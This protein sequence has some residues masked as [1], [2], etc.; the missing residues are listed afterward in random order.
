VHLRKAAAGLLMATS[1]LAVAT[2]VVASETVTHSY[3]ALGRLVTT[4]SS[5][6]VNNGLSTSIVFD[7][8]GNR[9]TY[10]VTG[11]G[12][13][14][15]PPPPPP[16]APPPP[17]PPPPLPPPPPPSGA[18]MTALNPTFNFTNASTNV[19]AL[20]TL[21]NPN[22]EPATLLTFTPPS[23]GGTATIAGDGQSVAYVAPS[24]PRPP[25]CE[26]AYTNSY[27]VPYSAQDTS[28]GATV[29]GT[30]TVNVRSQNGIMTGCP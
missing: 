15:P 14:P 3:D 29:S 5:G 16:P 1:V 13:A 30:A 10:T 22:G 18:T 27:S 2:S 26:L 19:I 20:T 25:R 28:N 8:A 9:S 4:T 17:A 21:V 24:L 7:P 11:A 23:G 6:T 12:G